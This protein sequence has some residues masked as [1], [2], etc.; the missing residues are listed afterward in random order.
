MR[1]RLVFARL[2]DSEAQAVLCSH[3]G[4]HW[5]AYASSL[6]PHSS[7]GLGCSLWLLF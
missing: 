2:S 6:V 4:L 1:S 3:L 7:L 5:L